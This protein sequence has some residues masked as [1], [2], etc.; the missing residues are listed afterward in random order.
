MQVP[1]L[2]SRQTFVKDAP[3]TK[4]DPSGTV[5]S[6]TNSARSQ[7]RFGVGVLVGPI[8]GVKVRVGVRVG[9]NVRVGVRVGV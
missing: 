9:V 1:T 7:L 5:T 4:V 3:G 8:V 6:V 2:R